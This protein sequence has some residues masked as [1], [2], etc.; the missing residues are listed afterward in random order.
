MN[1]LIT[2]GNTQTLIDKVR[3]ITNIFSGRTGSHIASHAYDRG[4]NVT[5][6]TS[7]PNVLNELPSQRPRV[8]PGFTVKAYQ[9][10]DDLEQLMASTILSGQFDAIIHAAAVNDYH[11]V[12][13]Y[14]RE[15]DDGS[16]IDVSS[17]KVKST[18]QDL[19]IRLQPAPKLVDKIRTEWRFAGTLVKFKLEVGVTDTELLGIAERSRLHSNADFIVANT[20]EGM[21]DW[22]FLGSVDEGY[23]HIPRIDLAEQLVR[24]LEESIGRTPRLGTA[25]N[26]HIHQAL[27]KAKQELSTELLLS[28]V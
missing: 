16:F 5:L 27:P 23:I 21:H 9:T 7:H 10:F 15:C 24:L 17:G 19:W 12:G 18:H 26:Q 20:L 6:L 13:T 3:C 11:V 25:M 8:K 2:A 14:A 22:A 28:A 4:H 1:L